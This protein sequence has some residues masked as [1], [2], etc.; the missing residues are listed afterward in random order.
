MARVLRARFPGAHVAMLIRRYTRE[1]VEDC[2][3]VDHI[4]YYDDG[5]KLVPLVKLASMLRSCRFDI[6]FHT[7]PRFR[8]SLIT[9]FA[10]IPVRVGTGYRWYS[11]LFNKK[12]YDHRKTAEHH[13]LEYNLRLLD[14][15]GYGRPELAEPI[16]VTP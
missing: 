5:G 10:G 16:D 6:V 9:W 7:Y 2:R 12:V 14:A 13:E 4:H 15:T 3:E 8:L 11:F 1:L